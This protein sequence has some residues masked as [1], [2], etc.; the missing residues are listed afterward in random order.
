[1]IIIDIREKDEYK[2]IPVKDGAICMPLS[3][4]TKDDY[5]KI[6]K[7]DN[8]VYFICRSGRRSKLLIDSIKNEVPHIKN[9]DGGYLKLTGKK[10]CTGCNLFKKLNKNKRRNKNE[11]TS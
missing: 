10:D 4:F 2:D 3:E 5:I 8:E 1:M 11:N 9:I 7:T 6:S